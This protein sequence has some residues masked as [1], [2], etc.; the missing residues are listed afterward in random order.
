MQFDVRDAK[1]GVVDVFMYLSEE[2][3]ISLTLPVR[4]EPVHFSGMIGMLPLAV[5]YLQNYSLP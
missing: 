4:S 1:N 2:L 5:P 3:S